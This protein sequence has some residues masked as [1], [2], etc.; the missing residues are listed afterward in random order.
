MSLTHPALAAITSIGHLGGEAAY[1]DA[2]FLA[3]RPEYE[4]MLRGVGIRSSWS[5]LEAGCGGGSHL[6]LLS[7]LVGPRGRLHALDLAPENIAAVQQLEQTGRLSCLLDT[8]VGS[9]L[10]LPLP[11]RSVDAVW[12]ANV[13]QYLIDAELRSMLLE[14]RR[15]TRPSGIVALK[16]IDAALFQIQPIPPAL[17]WH[18]F[19]TAQRQGV[20]QVGGCLRTAA[21]PRWMREAGFTNIT[22][23]TTPII[24]R[25]PLRP[26]ERHAIHEV[27]Q[28]LVQFAHD[29]R[30]P[31]AEL[32]QWHAYADS[33][34]ST[35]I[36][37][38]PDLCW[39]ET[40]TVI[41]GRAP[42][43]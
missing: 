7:A 27:V 13:S 36:L 4:A 3:L 35:Y 1:L 6:S 33:D 2:R 22:V 10:T 37:D 15:V 42:K 14:F 29:A 18:L 34:A 39:I 16:E 43:V 12:N 31:D 32:R 19:E 28:L 17:I 25:T 11:D 9:V 41:T 24:R 8:H 23:Q 40:Q 30:L 26:I 20:I 5:V 21:L 38:H